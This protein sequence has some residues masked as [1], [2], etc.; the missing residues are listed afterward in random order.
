M[1]NVCLFC[2]GLKIIFFD[3]LMLMD[4]LFAKKQSVNLTNSLLTVRHNESK[5]L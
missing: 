3:F 4:N 5:I 1:S 2:R